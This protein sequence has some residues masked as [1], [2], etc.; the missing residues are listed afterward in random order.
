MGGEVLTLILFGALFFLI[1]TGVP[2]TFALGIV[3][4]SVGFLEWGPFSIFLLSGQVTGAIFNQSL[5]SIPFFLLMASILSRTGIADDL[6]K[7]MYIWMGGLRGGLA[8]GTVL[9][10][11]GIAAMSGVSAVGVMSMGRLALPAMLKRH[12]DKRIA[13]GVILAGGA[14]GQLIPPS[15]MAIVLSGVSGV[16]IGKMFLAGLG[17]GLLLTALF[18]S[19]V[20]IRSW[21]KPDLCPAL[22]KVERD[23][24]TWRD[25][26]AATVRIVPAAIV[27]LSVLGSMFG[28]IAS[29]TEAAAMGAATS[30]IVAFAQGRLSLSIIPEICVEA[31]RQTTMVLWIAMTSLLFVAVYSGIG[32]QDIIREII[33]G[34]SL[35]PAMLIA[36]MMVIIFVLGFIMDPLGIIFL[37]MP[38]FV[39]MVIEVGFDLIWFCGLV[40][41]NLEMAYL[42]PPFGYNLFYLKSVAPKDVNIRDIYA[43]APQFVLL[44]MIGLIICCLAPWVITGLPE[45]VFGS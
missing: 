3:A 13:L 17:P 41:V 27:V 6:Y 32:G 11:A 35:S 18:C 5:I 34:L 42:T 22:P 14:L 20:L 28:G 40:I 21:M 25:R 19:Y 38:I 30:L 12:Y 36:A 8:A 45:A 15:L 23:A 2:I 26:A 39:P 9:V 44:Q 16:S 1:F 33:D 43:A 10:C 24:L 31:A 4:I 29:P 37:T 7:A